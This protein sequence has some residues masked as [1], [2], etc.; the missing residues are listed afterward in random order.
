M[1]NALKTQNKQITASSTVKDVWKNNLPSPSAQI[2]QNWNKVSFDV[3]DSGVSAQ[4]GLFGYD[5]TNFLADCQIAQ[6]QT[7]NG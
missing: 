7:N 2:I 4:V 3:A 1:S 5:F 6:D